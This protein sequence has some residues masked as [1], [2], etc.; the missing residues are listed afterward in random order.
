M[1]HPAT[2][3]PLQAIR[4]VGGYNPTAQY[5]EDLD[6]YLRLARVGKLSNLPQSLL[7]YR[8]H[9][10]SINFTRGRERA[11]AKAAIMQSAY[12]ARG[13]DYDPGRALGAGNRYGEAATHAKEWA[14]T[15]LQF[16]VRRVAVF[17]GLRA[18]CLA[19]SDLGSWR[20]LK[21]ALTAPVNLAPSLS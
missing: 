17:H 20:A 3:F 14:V 11:K 12:R 18:V 2:M 5:L 21:V 13:M 8:V 15:S 1:I 9:G 4:A 6:L 19:P 10:Q 16:G 7:R